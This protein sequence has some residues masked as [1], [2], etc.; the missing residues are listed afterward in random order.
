MR[1]IKLYDVQGLE[2]V[3]QVLDKL[4][5]VLADLVLVSDDVKS[6][7]DF[8]VLKTNIEITK[9]YYERIERLLLDHRDSGPIVVQPPKAR[10]PEEPKLPLMGWG[11][12]LS[13][14]QQDRAR[15]NST[16]VQRCLNNVS[17]FRTEFSTLTSKEQ[18]EFVRAQYQVL[19]V[20][21]KVAD[22]SAHFR[23]VT[24]FT[25]R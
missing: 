10:K 20:L 7:E 15:S 1:H 16:W 14:V 18:L 5:E 12:K 9:R 21:V 3:D 24:T 4:E 8:E 23:G 22:G 2:A 11:P 6:K 17:K 13:Q 25:Q 19:R